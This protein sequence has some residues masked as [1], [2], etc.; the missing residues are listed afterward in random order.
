[1]TESDPRVARQDSAAAAATTPRLL[2]GVPVP[3]SG[4]P[5][6]AGP[7]PDSAGRQGE[8][9]GRR[10]VPG[11]ACC[12][13]VLA[14][15]AV[16]GIA[17][18]AK[19]VAP[20]DVLRVLFTHAP[21][22]DDWIVVH[23][24]RLPRTLLGIAVGASL[25]LAGCLMQAL[26][27]NPLADP[28]L[29]GVNGGAAAAVAGATA[30]LD[31]R[32]FTAYVWF[33]LLGAVVAAV[34][35]YL[36]GGMGGSSAT[37]V[38]LA[39]AGTATTAVLTSLVSGLILLDPLT[40]NRFRFWQVGTFGGIDA[41][42]TAQ[43]APFLGVGAL[44][45]FALARSL[46]TMSLGAD[47]ARAL[48]TSPARVTALGLLTVTLLCGASTAAVGPIAFVG[49]AVPHAARFLAGSDLRWNLPYAAV[50]G[51][52]AVLAADVAGR[53]LLR[54]EEL[55]AGVVAAFLGAPLFIALVRRRKLAEL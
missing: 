42:V 50:L 13:A 45:A 32:T 14:L 55:E 28:G 9:G 16:A 30:L 52:V 4:H 26:T 12:L 15:L 43:V 37:P 10:L 35:V 11:L 46:N 23:T 24:S 2:S 49:L 29:L 3:A 7:T 41:G 36:L 40:L 21:A 18:G 25:G 19:D 27:R 5:V 8:W 22:D 44:L 34:A 6:P 1:M 17:V 53:V 47:T 48:G 20:A 31:L 33:A 54:P 38:R 51:A 39:L